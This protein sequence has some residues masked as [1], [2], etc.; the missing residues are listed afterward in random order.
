MSDTRTQSFPRNIISRLSEVS[1]YP[2]NA[3]T[4]SA[5]QIT[6]IANSIKEFGWTNPLLLDENNVVIAGHGRIAAALQLGLTEA[7][8]IV[9]EGLSEPQ[10]RA[11]RLADNKLALNAG[12]DYALLTSELESLEADNF[13]LALTGFGES[14]LA[15][16]FADRTE[17]L[18]DP[19]EVPE[20]GP[21]ICQPGDI[22]LLGRHR[23]VC[24]DATSATDHAAA[25]DGAQ[26]NAVV[27]DPPYGVAV[28]YDGFEHTPDNVRVLI[29]GFVPLARKW[30][31][32]AISTGQR[33]LWDYPRPDWLLGWALSRA[34]GN[35]PWGFT[36]YHPVVVY[37]RDP[38]L[39]E[40]MGGR[41]D[42]AVELAA[43]RES[44]KNHPTV[45][46]VAWWQWLVERVTTHAGQRV[47]DP[48]VGSGTTIIAAEMT[49]RSCHALE[50]SP[51]Y[52]DVAI[53]R[54]QN[55]T[56]QT[57]TKPDGTPY[58]HANATPGSRGRTEAQAD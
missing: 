3:R 44:N 51:R 8:S 58:D 17:G 29:G 39:A 34:T 20:P 35:G 54:W 53:I 37:G 10:K 6:Q 1:G 38:Y 19:D 30:P 4:H 12:W 50:I 7:P 45:K 48:F 47:L 31:V 18:T 9:L 13:D 32:V 57:A 33:C 52:C 22:W 14:E 2:T 28:Q 25:I 56:G 46:P 55:F 16:L 42:T 24:G 21:P 36:C 11:L 26:I 15:D 49:G 41:P 5:E 23:L 27:T 43:D 40:R